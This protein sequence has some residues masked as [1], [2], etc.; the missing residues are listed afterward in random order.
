MQFLTIKRHQRQR[1]DGRP[2][3]QAFVIKKT[4]KFGE[5]LEQKGISQNSEGLGLRSPF[6]FCPPLTLPCSTHA[7]AAAPSFSAPPASSA[8]RSRCLL[9]AQDC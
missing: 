1:K 5:V 9:V 6:L 7:L 4:R 2:H 8:A 3:A